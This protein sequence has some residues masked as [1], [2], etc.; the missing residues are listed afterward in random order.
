MFVLFAV[1]GHFFLN[2]CSARDIDSAGRF[3]RITTGIDMLGNLSSIIFG[4]F[5]TDGTSP[6]LEFGIVDQFAIAN[7][8]IICRESYIFL[9]SLRLICIFSSDG[10][11]NSL[12]S[13][14]WRWCNLIRLSRSPPSAH[15][16]MQF[17]IGHFRERICQVGLWYYSP[18][19]PSIVWRI[20]TWMGS[21]LGVRG[22]R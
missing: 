22:M 11:K 7:C 5:S 17:G 14:I 13:A 3:V 6:Y 18:D 20:W 2:M 4:D 1:F 9:A 10:R 15:Q 21:G 12:T 19:S 16:V 8:H